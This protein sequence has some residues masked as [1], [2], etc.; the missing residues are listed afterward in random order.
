VTGAIDRGGNMR[1]RSVLAIL[2][3]FLVVGPTLEFLWSLPYALELSRLR[4]LLHAEDKPD[5]E[6]LAVYPWAR[7]H[8]RPLASVPSSTKEAVLF[9]HVPRSGGTTVKVLYEC[10]GLTLANKAGVD[11]KFRH[12]NKREIVVF[13]PWPGVSRASY[14]N[15]D[16]TNKQGLNR[17]KNM[18]LVPS[19][20]VDMIIT[21]DIAYAVENLFDVSSKGRVLGLFRHPVDRLVSMFYYLQIAK[22]ER[23][24]R[25]Q[26]KHVPIESFADKINTD[27]NHMVKKMAG[28]GV[29]GT[30][31]ELDLRVAM[32]TVK[33]RFVVGLLEKM[34]ESVHRFNIVMGVN[35][36]DEEN[37]QCINHFFHNPL[38]AT[39]HHSNSH[40][41]VVKGSPAWNMFAKNNALDIRLYEFIV[42]IFDEQKDI[43]ETYSQLTPMP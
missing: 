4:Q 33:R 35:E 9:W 5:N 19:G 8:L 41:A 37:K 12:Q 10:L 36:S 15:V 42:R 2:A 11:P 6:E 38:G 18:G 21:A 25:P 40:P 26:W 29:N 1:T 31:T 3:G 7:N 27:N 32:R 17:A 28:V 16:T 20:V 30:V 34:E 24:Y 14:V 22:W 39:K 43:I 13:Q 23:Q